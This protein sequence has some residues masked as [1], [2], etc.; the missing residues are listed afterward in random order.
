M[1][2]QDQEKKQEETPEEQP[3]QPLS[4]SGEAKTE[5]ITEAEVVEEVEAE[6][7][8][9]TDEKAE[10]LNK[11]VKSNL[12]EE[13]KLAR[14]DEFK[15]VGD[16]LNYAE[17]LIRSNLVPK[18][19][20]RP[21]QVVTVIQQGRELG[22]G[23]ITSLNN[24][25]NIKNKATLSVH[26]IGALLKKAGIKYKIIKDYEDYISYSDT[27]KDA[28]NNPKILG[29]TKITTIRFYEKFGNTVI[30][31]D[32][33]YTWGEATVAGLVTKD[34]WIKMPKIMLRNRCLA[35]GARF[36]APDALLGMYETSE[37]AEVEGV[38]LKLDDEGKVIE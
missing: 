19:L 16:M 25:H 15:T 24:I 32:M 29:R 27:E 30:E 22:F 7:E 13:G 4:D 26:A 21:E 37:L 3:K 8:V 31:N 9:M 28:N 1:Q 23:A 38:D 10:R 2:T 5:V 12:S 35:I 17:V 36:V 20:T 6:V 33:S 11:L 34:N 18:T 14:L